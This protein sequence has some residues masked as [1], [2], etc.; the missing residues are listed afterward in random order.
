MMGRSVLLALGALAALAVAEPTRP[1][2]RALNVSAGVDVELDE[3]P[4]IEVDLSLGIGHYTDPDPPEDP[5]YPEIP[6]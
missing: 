6:P 3:T 4:E 5:G 2:T 1:D